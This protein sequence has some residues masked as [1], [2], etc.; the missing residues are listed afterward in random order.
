MRSG[1]GPDAVWSQHVFRF[2]GPL[3][4]AP[5]QPPV[6]LFAKSVGIVQPRQVSCPWCNRRARMGSRLGLLEKRIQQ[7]GC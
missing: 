1:W 3:Q 2:G 4:L 7:P 6:A 5:P